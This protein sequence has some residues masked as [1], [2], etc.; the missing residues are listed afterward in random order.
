MGR[1]DQY[2]RVVQATQAMLD[3][4][5]S[6][7]HWSLRQMYYRLVATEVLENT[8]NNY[9]NLSRWLTKA[10]EDGIIDSRKFEDRSRKTHGSGDRNPD[11]PEDYMESRIKSLLNSYKYFEYSLWSDQEV[12]LEVWI[13]KDALTTLFNDVGRKYNIHTCPCK[14]YPS[15]SYVMEAVKR[16][17]RI[18][19]RYPDRP[20]KILYFGDFDPS[21]LNIPENLM[22]RFVRY[23][24]FEEGVDI[25]LDRK[26]LTIPQINQ[27][28]LPPAPAKKSDVRYKRFTEITGTDLSVELDA[29][30]P[31]IL[32]AM[33]KEAIEEN[34]IADRWDAKLD[35]SSEGREKL[36][37]ALQTLD[38]EVD[39]DV[40]EEDLLDD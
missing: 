18:Q 35:E 30:E 32:Q 34:I 21:G 36:R 37:I 25:S 26:A 10:R 15:Y 14:G 23:G 9:K 13:E 12:Y 6:V 5:P 33:V 38:L 4:Y 28:E 8:I 39:W 7:D 22:E 2:N 27:Y 19:E 1:N 3:K 29:L 20:I 17:W 11:S 40:T 24:N 31:Y 16:F